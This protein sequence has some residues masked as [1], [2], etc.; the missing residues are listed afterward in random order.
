MTRTGHYRCSHTA[1][2][3][4]CS[5]RPQLQ[6]GPTHR[7]SRKFWWV[8]DAAGQGGMCRA[9]GG[10]GYCSVVKQVLVGAC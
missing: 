8:Q 6:A 9:E 3:A 5:F 4:T 10:G 1:A 7:W 2:S